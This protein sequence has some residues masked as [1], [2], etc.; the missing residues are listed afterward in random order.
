MLCRNLLTFLILIIVIS[1]F[2]SSMLLRRITGL[3]SKLVSQ[4]PTALLTR[5]FASSYESIADNNI[6]PMED[7]AGPKVFYFTATWCPPCKMIAPIFE[8]LSKENPKTK[9]VKIDIDDNMDVA[10]KYAINSVPTF[11][12]MHGQ[13]V[14]AKFSGASEAMLKQHIADLQDPNLQ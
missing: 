12:F 4:R 3:S 5:Q 1:T 2:S 14:Q 11:M 9:F 10:G 6:K 13:K 8:Q 7:L